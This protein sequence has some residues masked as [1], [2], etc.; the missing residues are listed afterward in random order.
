MAIKAASSG[1]INQASGGRTLLT[2]KGGATRSGGTMTDGSADNT[3]NAA[4][5]SSK[6]RL[7]GRMPAGD[8]GEQGFRDEGQKIGP[9]EYQAGSK[10]SFRPKTGGRVR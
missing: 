3:P 4:V 9:K 2:G 1:T 10:Q 6:V 5:G 7:N 8:T